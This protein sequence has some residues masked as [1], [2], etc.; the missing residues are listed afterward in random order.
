[1]VQKFFFVVNIVLSEELNMTE[2]K[3]NFDRLNDF[4]WATW[5]FRMELLLMK[6]DLWSVV[7]DVK[8]DAA[9][10]TSAWARKDEKAR[11]MIG[12]ALEDCQLSHIMDAASAN[13]M[14]EKLKGYH[15]RGS[16]SNKIHVLRRLC[17]MQLTE[18]GNMSEHLVAATEMVHRLARMGESLKEHL[19]VAI[20]L[21]S[22][23]ESYNPL[24][25]ALEGRPEE[26]LKLDYVKGKLLDEW[27]RKCEHSNENSQ[28]KAMRSFVHAAN[29]RGVRVCYCC[30]QAGHFRNNCPIFLKYQQDKVETMNAKHSDGGSGSSRGVCFTTTT[31]SQAVN[32]K[33]WII[34]TGCTKHMTGSVES[35]INTLPWKEKVSLADGR[36]VTAKA[37]GTAK[38]IGR[39]PGGASVE[40]KL[41][42]LLYVPGLSGNVLSVSRITEEGYCV[43][44]GLEDCHI[45]DRGTVIAVGVK[46]GGLYYLKE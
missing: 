29:H 7:N 19:V 10:V 11:A 39:E 28:Q 44:F 31:G 21:S 46:N 18:G 38:I 40:T 24:V 20:L 22:L 8:P 45:L 3:I 16:L 36:T 6:D 33:R 35:F 26:D 34:D 9:S 43:Q 15:E 13:D 41:K 2:A 27:R 30:G 17:S 32:K 37:R 4:N 25:T 5:R 23:P 42:E 14:W 1:M 12:L